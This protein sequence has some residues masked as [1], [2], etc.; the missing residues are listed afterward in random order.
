MTKKKM[1]EVLQEREAKF[2]LE[3]YRCK[4]LFGEE[5]RIF[6]SARSSWCDVYATLAEV[7]VKPNYLLP[8]HRESVDIIMNTENHNRL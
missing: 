8:D 1:I 3:M 2:N 7:N 5:H 6:K 4:A